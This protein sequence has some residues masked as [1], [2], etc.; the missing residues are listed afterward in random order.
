MV[1]LA[2][3]YS[4]IL[5]SSHDTKFTIFSPYNSIR[6]RHY[7]ILDTYIERRSSGWRSEHFLC[8]L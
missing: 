4:I 7:L 8:I 6:K 2:L 1:N 3:Q 5:N